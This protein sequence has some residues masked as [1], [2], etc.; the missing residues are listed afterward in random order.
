MKEIKFNGYVRSY[1]VRA[2]GSDLHIVNDLYN[3]LGDEYARE[4]EVTIRIRDKRQEWIDKYYNLAK[5]MAN[6]GTYVIKHCKEVCYVI[7]CNYA[8]DAASA[9]PRHGDKYDYKTGVAVAFAKAFGDRV[10]DYI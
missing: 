8:G 7:P 1:G 3:R 6:A 4:C 9:T 5:R 2:M 10:P